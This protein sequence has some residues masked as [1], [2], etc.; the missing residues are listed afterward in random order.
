M[1]FPDEASSDPEAPLDCSVNLNCANASPAVIRIENA[2]ICAEASE[3]VDPNFKPVDAESHVA[4][5]VPSAPVDSPLTGVNITGTPDTG[6]ITMIP[7]AT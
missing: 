6:Y 5:C 2:E 7:L 1:P 4:E 3:P